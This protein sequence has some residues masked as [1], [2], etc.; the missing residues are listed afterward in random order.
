MYNSCVIGSNGLVTFDVSN[1]GLVNAWSLTTVPNGVIPQP[2]PY[3]GGSPNTTSTT[4]YPRAAIMGA[5]HDIFP[6][7]D[8]GGQ[9][10]IEYR[11]EGVTPCRKFVVS[12]YVVPLY[13]SA[14]CNGRY[15]TQ[16]IVLHESTGIIAVHLGD[17]PVCNSWNQGLAI[18]GL[19]NWNRNAAVTAPGKNCTVWSESGTSYR[20]I[21]SG[22]GSRGGYAA[23]YL[24]A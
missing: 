16:Q 14:V 8:A 19:Q 5:Y 21:P 2:V 9:R 1:A 11:T 12:F 22:P 15:C 10:K 7:L 13:G 4:Y 3:T 17:K 18:L 6:L 23:I 20:F 24:C